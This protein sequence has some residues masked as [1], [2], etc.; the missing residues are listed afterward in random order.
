MANI[1]SKVLFI[2]TSPRTPFRMIPEIEL[3]STHFAGK[4]WNSE[5]QTAFMQLL[6]EEN[7]FNGEGVNDPAF[8]AGD[9]LDN[10]TQ[11]LP[12]IRGVKDI[13]WR[14]VVNPLRNLRIINIFEYIEGQS[15]GEDQRLVR[16]FQETLKLRYRRFMFTGTLAYMLWG[17]EDYNRKFNQTYPL[18]WKT[19]LAWS[20]KPV[21]NFSDS[22]DRIG[23][24]Y[25][26]VIKDRYSENFVSR[27]SQEIA[28]F[29]NF[30]F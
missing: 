8:S 9:F 16:G 13:A 29:C 28:L 10:F 26:G 1:S 11:G 14:V 6:R 22:Y 20:F 18:R 2:T 5:I 21:P 30:R 15:Q 24:R 25:N 19:E 23:I 27:D 7:F 17:I 3:L 4:K 12:A